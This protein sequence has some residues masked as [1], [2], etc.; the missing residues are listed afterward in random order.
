ME[1]PLRHTKG[2]I[3]RKRSLSCYGNPLRHTTSPI[4]YMINNDLDKY[5]I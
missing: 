5:F 1:N 4:D 2:H 3:Y